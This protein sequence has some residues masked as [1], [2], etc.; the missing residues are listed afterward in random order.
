MQGSEVLGFSDRWESLEGDQA[1]LSSA[2]AE[3]G[4]GA[5]KE[6]NFILMF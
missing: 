3:A 1:D 5:V 2:S 4:R 6:E